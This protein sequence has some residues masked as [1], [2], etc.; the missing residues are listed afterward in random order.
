MFDAID[1]KQVGFV[2]YTIFHEYILYVRFPHIYY[3]DQV[4]KKFD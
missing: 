3:W 1:W 2:G 4:K